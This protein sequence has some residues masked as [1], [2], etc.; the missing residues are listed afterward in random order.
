MRQ[1]VRPKYRQYGDN[2]DK[3]EQWKTGTFVP[4]KVT[5]AYRGKQ[6]CSFTHS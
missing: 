3:Q 5:K 4:V 1:H 2:T 6:G